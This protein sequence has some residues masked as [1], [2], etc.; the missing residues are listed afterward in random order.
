[1]KN[2]I[3]FLLLVVL[4]ISLS[5]FLPWWIVAPLSLGA[6]YFTKSKPLSG[7]F[8][9]FIAIF[10]AWLISIV[11]NESGNVGELMGKLFQVD[12]DLIPFIAS[13]IG[14]LVAGFFGLAGSLLSVSKKTWVNG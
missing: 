2:S 12:S 10:L 7:F 11:F 5:L 4:T 14:A 3:T 13:L 6:T 8:I 1:M 9:P